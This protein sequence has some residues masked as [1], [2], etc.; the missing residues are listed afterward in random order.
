M[1]SW[2]GDKYV[3][4]HLKCNASVSSVIAL[5]YSNLV[6]NMECHDCYFVLCKVNCGICRISRTTRIQESIK[7]VIVKQTSSL[8]LLCSCSRL[9]P[10]EIAW[11]M[12]TL[13][14]LVCPTLI[15]LGKYWC[16]YKLFPFDFIKYWGGKRDKRST[17]VGL[18]TDS[19]A[20]SPTLAPTPRSPTLFSGI[21]LLAPLVPQNSTSRYA[22]IISTFPNEAARGLA[23][24]R[25]AWPH[26]TWHCST[27]Q[28]ID[29]M[30]CILL[31]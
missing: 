25:I 6:L 8:E 2:V 5:A 17:A 3:T 27:G 23:Y 30:A 1:T 14:C 13:A 20:T 11:K 31:W 15:L 12:V 19:L 4:E 21:S 9:V 29:L 22:S 26:A 7:S 10:P 28:G 16:N 24:D 18:D